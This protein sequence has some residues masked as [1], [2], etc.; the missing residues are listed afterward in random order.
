MTEDHDTPETTPAATEVSLGDLASS[1][2]D[3][4]VAEAPVRESRGPDAHGWFRGTGRRKAAVARVRLKAG[5]GQFHIRGR[6]RTR[7]LEE[8]FNETRDRDSITNVLKNTDTVGKVDVY[9][10]C[11]GGGFMGQA[12]AI[13]LGL[14]RALR[15]FDPGLESNLREHGYLTR[16]A[17]KVER[18]KY[19]QAGARRRF[20]FSKR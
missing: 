16:D 14:G 13:V 4:A 11:D 18:K 1:A 9:V 15:E 3:V 10:N 12:G 17:R 5:S 8:Y 20:Q 6:V 2:A 7:P 19:G